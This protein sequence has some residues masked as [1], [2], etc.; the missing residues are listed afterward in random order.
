MRVL[1]LALIGAALASCT[2][3]PEPVQRNAEKERELQMLLA[4]KAAGAP[5]SCLPNYSSNDMQIIDGR[6]VAFRQGGRTVYLMHLSPGCQLLGRGNYALLTR[7]SGGMGYCRG[8]IVHV[9]DPV[10]HITVGSCG[11]D[12]IVPYTRTGRY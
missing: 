5:V 6:D 7:Q 1:S 2:T 12:G 10:S 8:D 9:F 11:I 4:G 3:A